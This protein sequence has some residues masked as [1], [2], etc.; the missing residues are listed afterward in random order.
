MEEEWSLHL[1]LDE[2]AG[3]HVVEVAMGTQDSQDSQSVCPN[4]RDEFGR[5]SSR[6][7][8]ERLAGR[9]SDEVAVRLPT[10]AGETTH[11]HLHRIVA[12]TGRQHD[13]LGRHLCF[14][15]GLDLDG[16]LAAIAAGCA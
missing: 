12:S 2:S 5:S 11:G 13:G 16:R 3:L 14:R 9:R 6:I 1:F 4:A 8:D 7:D 10:S 15:L